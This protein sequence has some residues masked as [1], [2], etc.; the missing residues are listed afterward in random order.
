MKSVVTGKDDAA[1][2]N[3]CER[4]EDSAVSNY[5]AALKKSLP[6]DLLAIVEEQ[7]REVKQAHDTVRDLKRANEKK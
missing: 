2:V 5:Q 1:I 3:E 4:G 6:S 7:Y